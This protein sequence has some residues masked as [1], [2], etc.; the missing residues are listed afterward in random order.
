MDSITCAF[1]FKRGSLSDRAS[2]DGTWLMRYPSTV[3]IWIDSLC[4]PHAGGGK[5]CPTGQLQLAINDMSTGSQEIF[6]NSLGRKCMFRSYGKAAL[7]A[8]VAASCGYAGAATLAVTGATAN[9]SKEGAASTA[10]T[11]LAI[12]T[13]V[14]L[15]MGSFQARDNVIRLSLGGIAGAKFA[16]TSP[17][18]SC[19][20]GNIV[21]DVPTIAAGST[22]ID[23]GI[24]G[25]SGTTSSAVCTFT[26]H[27]VVPNSL[28]AGGN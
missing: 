16:T 17:S 21:L 14:T 1:P 18:V 9:V 15:T 8:A 27:N 19:T 20:T 6:V 13:N 23:F 2:P 4:N 11:T 25:T 28:S 22:T 26:S 7:I 5:T 3:D 10:D 12:G 24:T